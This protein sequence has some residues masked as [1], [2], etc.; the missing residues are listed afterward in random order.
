LE[1][2]PEHGNLSPT[3]AGDSLAEEDEGEDEDEEPN[4]D[5]SASEDEQNVDGENDDA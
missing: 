4:K 5:A 1:Y 2:G 3:L